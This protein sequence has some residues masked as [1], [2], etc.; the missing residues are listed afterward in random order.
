MNPEI[1]GPYMWFILHLITFNYPKN[2]SHFDKQAYA[3]F[4][5]ALKDVLPCY[6]CKKHYAKT[7]QAYPITPNLDT[8]KQL[9]EWLIKIHNEVN[10]SLGKPVLSTLQVLEIY[11]NLDPIS[12]FIL[13]DQEKVNTTIKNKYFKKKKINN[14]ILYFI[15][16]VLLILVL[17]INLHYNKN[18]YKYN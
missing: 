12:P 5:T 6:N 13:Y 11:K 10:I 14:N 9:I 17:M 16:F 1:W 15:I 8:K 2:P 3:D 18:Y 7:I 4:F